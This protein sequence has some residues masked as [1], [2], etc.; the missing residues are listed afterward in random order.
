VQRRSRRWWLLTREGVLVQAL[1]VA[2]KPIEARH[3]FVAET[4]DV[5]AQDGDLG[6]D[7]PEHESDDRDE[8]R[9]EAADHRPYL[10]ARP[11]RGL[12][13]RPFDRVTGARA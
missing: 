6:A 2:L 7:E 3:E 1:H 8:D 13:A 5:F 12:L 10:R 11:D 9:E 4:V